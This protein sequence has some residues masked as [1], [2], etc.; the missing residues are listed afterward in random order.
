MEKVFPLCADLVSPAEPRHH[1]WVKGFAQGAIKRNIGKST[2]AK[3]P[4]P[5]E[6]GTKENASGCWPVRRCCAKRKPTMAGAKPSSKGT[7]INASNVGPLTSLLSTTRTAM[8]ADRSAQTTRCQ[9]WKRFAAPATQRC[10][11]SWIGR[12]ASSDAS[13]AARPNGGTM[14]K[15]YAGNAT[16]PRRAC[17]ASIFEHQ[18]SNSETLKIGVT[19]L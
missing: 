7:G 4:H 13:N 6:P 1:L 5:N 18:L 15:D 12:E 10:I 16:A 11:M 14:P 19:T 17:A 8:G 9:T 2:Q 3:S